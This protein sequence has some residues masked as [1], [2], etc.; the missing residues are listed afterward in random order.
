MLVLAWLTDRRPLPDGVE[1]LAVLHATGNDWKR[2]RL[3]GLAAVPHTRT[4]LMTLA[5][6]ADELALSQRQVERLVRAGDLPAIEIGA[7]R[8][9]AREDLIAFVATH[10]RGEAMSATDSRVS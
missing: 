9:I 7:A 4:M 1:V 10:R 2:H 5:E 8:R 3:A 6:A